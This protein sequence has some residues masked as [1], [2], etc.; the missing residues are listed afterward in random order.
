MRGRKSGSIPALT[1]HINV[2]YRQVNKCLIEPTIIKKSSKDPVKNQAIQVIQN[3]HMKLFQIVFSNTKD[4]VQNVLQDEQSC[5]RTKMPNSNILVEMVK[6]K[7]H[8]VSAVCS[9]NRC[10]FFFPNCLK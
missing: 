7:T 10:K 5:F 4:V 1:I 3:S 6:H 8:L 9:K 2:D